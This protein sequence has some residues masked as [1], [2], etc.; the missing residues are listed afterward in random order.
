MITTSQIWNDAVRQ[1][2]VATDEIP[3]RQA[4]ENLYFAVFLDVRALLGNRRESNPEG[5]HVAVIEAL[6]RSVAE[7]GQRRRAAGRLESLR[8]LRNRARYDIG[9]DVSRFE[10]D[11]AR[12]HADAVRTLLGVNS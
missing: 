11:E 7:G 2:D 8:R 5:S 1:A 4:I 6:K 10:L 12:R 9:E 3:R